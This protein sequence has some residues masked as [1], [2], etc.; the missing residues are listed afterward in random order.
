MSYDGELVGFNIRVERTKARMTQQDLAKATGIDA[1]TISKY[2][3]GV[4][5]PGIDKAFAIVRALGCT[6]DD[7]CPVPAPIASEVAGADE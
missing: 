3:K 7:I 2:E 4:T 5:T 6:L 1:T